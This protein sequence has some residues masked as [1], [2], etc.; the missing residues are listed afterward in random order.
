MTPFQ[1]LVVP[2]ATIIALCHF[3]ACFRE[4]SRLVGRLIWGSIFLS[5]AICV[6]FPTLPNMMANLL[7]V[8]R[9]ADL[10]L[11]GTAVLLVL[12]VR[13]DYLR[14]R[15]LKLTITEIVRELAIEKA[16][17]GGPNEEEH[18]IPGTPLRRTA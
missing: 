4:R 8:G 12:V 11:Y 16:R 9:G 1:L 2:A 5:I 10:V 6:T 17:F 15:L 3:V 7:G 18:T 13:R 14:H